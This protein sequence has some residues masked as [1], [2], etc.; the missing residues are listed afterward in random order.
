MKV[1]NKDT[2]HLYQFSGDEAAQEKLIIALDSGTVKLSMM[3]GVNFGIELELEEN[4]VRQI[5][6]LLLRLAPKTNNHKERREILSL[7]KDKD[8][9][10]EIKSGN[11]LLEVYEDNRGEPFRKGVSFY[12][13][14]NE[15]PT[16]ISMFISDTWGLRDAFEAISAKMDLY[17]EQQDDLSFRL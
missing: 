3:E 12:Y 2:Q 8:R 14:K 16:S 5:N 9:E 11:L 4:E 1:H 7:L 17:Q 13:H 15:C 10:I 6:D